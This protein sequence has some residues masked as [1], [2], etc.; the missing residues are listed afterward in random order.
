MGTNMR[1]AVMRQWIVLA[2]GLIPAIG[3]GQQNISADVA[4]LD[5]ARILSAAAQYLNQ[6]PITVTAFPA[7]RSAGGVHEYF[8]EGDYWWPDPK[9]PD[10]PYIRRD[11][12]TNP[13]NFNRHRDAL[14]RFCDIVSG[15]T[16][17]FRITGGRE[18]CRSGNTTFKSMV[19]R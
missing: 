18:L 1:R 9:N 19:R 3:L 7:P 5:R 13:D 2:A 10:G 8:S 17:A 16:A 6:P 4:S 14:R 15:L 11:G 12:E